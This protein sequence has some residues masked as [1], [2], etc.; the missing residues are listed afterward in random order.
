MFLT[1]VPPLILR[2]FLLRGSR[3]STERRSYRDRQH[4]VAAAKIRRSEPAIYARLMEP[5][6]H[7]SRST[8][9]VARTNGY[10]AGSQLRFLESAHAADACLNSPLVFACLAG[11]GA[12]HPH[13]NLP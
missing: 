13:L 5:L 3:S 4:E 6:P 8:R 12:P 9:G 10:P 11:V 2:K 7:E 1:D